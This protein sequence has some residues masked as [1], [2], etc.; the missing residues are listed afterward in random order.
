MNSV[1]ARPGEAI[2]TVGPR[3]MPEQVHGAALNACS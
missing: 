2:A 3:P 1:L